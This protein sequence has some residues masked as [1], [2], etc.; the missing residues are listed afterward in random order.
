MNQPNKALHDLAFSDFSNTF[1][2][3]QIYLL[4]ISSFSFFVTYRYRHSIYEFLR[5]TS[6]F[7]GNKY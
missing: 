6:I 3:P 1:T 4:Y 2:F 5:E 7:E